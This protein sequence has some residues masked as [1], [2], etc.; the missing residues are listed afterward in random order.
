[1]IT[2]IGVAMAVLGAMMAAPVQAKAAS[3]QIPIVGTTAV[4]DR[5]V[6]TF[7]LERFAVDSANKVVAIGTISGVAAN[8][9]GEVLA[10][11]LATVALPVQVNGNT[12]Q[13]MALAPA[14][15]ASCSILHLDLGPLSL[16]LLGLQVNLNEVVLDIS[17]LPGAGNLL[18]NLLCAVTNLLNNPSGLAGLLNQVLGI[19][20]GL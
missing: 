19:V 11:G 14:V 6:G 15:A 12:A 18:G 7:T 10:T 5:F 17:A 8:A 9:L 16:N 20:Q 4:G 1:M 2:R 13:T 3:A